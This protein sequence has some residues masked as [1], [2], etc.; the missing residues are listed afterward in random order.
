MLSLAAITSRAATVS[1]K[2][3]P[4]TKEAI[5]AMTPQQKQTRLDEIK[6]RMG[7]I[8][9]MDKSQ[10][11]RAERREL[12]VEVRSL[13]KE[14]A[15]MVGIIYIGAGLIVFIGLLLIIFLR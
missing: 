2:G 11:T 13:R 6:L 15:D 3:G 14:S 4:L 9:G 1:V 5:A 12:R 10:L 8:K 7:E